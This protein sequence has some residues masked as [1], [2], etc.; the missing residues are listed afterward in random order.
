ME[1]N[2][3]KL[4]VIKRALA[5]VMLCLMISGTALSLI[6]CT[7]NKNTFYTDYFYC[8]YNDDKTEVT[9]LDLTAKGQEQEVLIIPE[10]IND[11]TVSSL[12]GVTSGYP[13]QNNHYPESKN[14][15]KLYI[16]ANYLSIEGVDFPSLTELIILNESPFDRFIFHDMAIRIND[17]NCFTTKDV[18][19]KYTDK[20]TEHMKIGQ[21]KR[22]YIANVNFIELDGTQETIKW[23]DNISD[24]S[25]YLLPVD[26]GIWYID[27]ECTIEW[28]G[29]YVIPVGQEKLNL[30]SKKQ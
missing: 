18:Y 29:T 27:K 26:A 8:M 6:G 1:S 15:K 11:L 28:D 30:Y 20:I 24:S 5:A 9:I 7:H 16:Y 21:N 25:L 14:L 10:T 17:I 23:I 22:I 2:G 12:G 4:F 3:D 19:L 13:Y